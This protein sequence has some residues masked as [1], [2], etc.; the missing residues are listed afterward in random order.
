MTVHTPI[1]GSVI[2]E[3]KLANVSD[4]EQV[5][6]AAQEAFIKWR[7]VPAPARGEV[8]RLLGE[9]FRKH[10]TELGNTALRKFRKDKTAAVDKIEAARKAEVKRKAKAARDLEAP[11]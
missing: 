9:E 1:D 7:K 2:G 4:Y 6:A 3:V 8:I 11:L 10:K 5:M